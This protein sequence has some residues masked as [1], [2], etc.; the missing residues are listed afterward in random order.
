MRSGAGAGLASQVAIV[1]R[2]FAEML[3]PSGADR[4][5]VGAKRLEQRVG[6]TAMAAAAKGAPQQLTKVRALEPAPHGVRVNALTPGRMHT[7]LTRQ[8][9]VEVRQEIAVSR[10]LGRFGEVRELIGAAPF[11]ASDTSSF[12]TG[13]SLIVDG[14][15]TA[16]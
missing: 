15:R 14:G 8:H 11:L 16:H 3:A 9:V 12:V 1:T 10:S 2:A 13:T 4:R 5:L 7:P 6:G